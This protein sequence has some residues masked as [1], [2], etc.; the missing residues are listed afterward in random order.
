MLRAIIFDFD[1]IIV[2][3][4]PLIFQLTRQ[5]AAQE[6]W[7][8]TEGEYFHD[9]LALDDRGIVEHLYRSHGRPVDAARR[10]ELVS[11][12]VRA[13]ADE[14]RDGLPPL[15]GAVEFVRSLAPQFPLA[16]ASGSLRSEIEH[17]LGKLGL[18][19]AFQVVVAADDV[20]RS[21][22]APD[23]FLK[24]LDALRA[25]PAFCAAEAGS[26]DVPP[27]PLLARECLVIEDAPNGVRAARAAGM[28]C[29]ALAHSRPLAELAHADWVSRDFAGVDMAAII[30]AFHH[31]PC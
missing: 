1:G 16:I 13:Y 26:H 20:E 2:D 21:K 10:D 3:S 15:P 28:P 22:P 27:A 24:A 11:W 7:T 19:D 18:R 9:Y 12:K 23:I 30:A 14:I 31:G 5:M 25:L 4:E 8:I 17:L 29:L 6:G